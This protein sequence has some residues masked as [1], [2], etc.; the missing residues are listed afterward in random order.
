RRPFVIAKAAVS[1]DNRVAARRGER[2][3]ISSPESIRHAHGVRAEVDAIGVGSE[4]VLID[5]PLLTAREIP[6]SRPLVRVVFDRRL[7][8]P[9]TARLFSTLDAGPVIIIT[10]PDTLAGAGSRAAAL[11]R[12]GGH[13]EAVTDGDLPAALQRLGERQVVSLLLEGG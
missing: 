3:Q 4:T 12:A 10:T 11:E 7:R 2:A 8:V 1:S 13:V 9:P 5:D 6:R